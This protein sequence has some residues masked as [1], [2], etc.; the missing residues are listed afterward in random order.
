M[1]APCWLQTA[2]LRATAFR[3]GCIESK[4]RPF[5]D[6]SDGGCHAIA[7]NQKVPSVVGIANAL[8]ALKPTG[9]TESGN[10]YVH[11][12]DCACLPRITDS[13][14]GICH[15][16]TCACLVKLSTSQQL[17]YVMVPLQ[18]EVTA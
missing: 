17:K 7:S 2:A 4:E 16:T 18:L 11:A 8:Q 5:T 1:P 13:V 14:A 12:V 3:H 9:L 10:L 6:N 15:N